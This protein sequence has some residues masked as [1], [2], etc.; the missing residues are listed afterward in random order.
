[1]IYGGRSSEHEVSVVSASSIVQHLDRDLYEVIPIRIRKN[2][3]WMIGGGTPTA[4]STAE[5][6]ETLPETNA[7]DEAHLVAH[8]GSET[9][10]RIKR[11]SVPAPEGLAVVSGF[12]LDV[13]FPVLHGPHGEDGTIQGLLELAN[14]PYVGAGVL[15]SAV[16]M[17]KA[18]MKT[19]FAAKG[20]PQTAY[21]VVL[22]KQWY[23]SPD[24]VVRRVD[25]LNYPVFVKPANLGSSVGISKVHAPEELSSAMA[26]ALAFD[27][28]IVVEASVD[29]ARE[30]ECAVLGNDEPRVSAPGEII[31]S[32]EFYDY[33][34]KYLKN[35]L[36]L[37]IPAPVSESVALDI[38]RLTLAAFHTV[39][40]C[41]MARVDFLMSRNNGSLLVNEINTIPGFTAGSMYPKLWEAS[42]IPYAELLAQLIK[43]AI[44]RHA[45]KQQLR[46]SRV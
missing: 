22:S 20:L 10:L 1:L 37:L 5:A 35:N 23:S 24:E 17:D 29:D 32:G 30:L 2:G 42:G 21:V 43:F 34:A 16:S 7:G 45:E 19:L 12:N 40:A 8:P 46:T 27:R 33:G 13:I 38:Q 28:K 39:E 9:L 4:L 41:G 18:I 15:S 36:R 11:A 3:R 6:A 31:S 25:A 44:E 26:T 14:V